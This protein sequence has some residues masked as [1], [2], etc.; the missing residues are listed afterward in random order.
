MERIMSES[1][2]GHLSFEVHYLRSCAGPIRQLLIGSSSQY[3]ALPD[4]HGAYNGLHNIHRD[5]MLMAQKQ[6]RVKATR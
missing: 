1:R 5:D 3:L 2:D 6:V 4:G